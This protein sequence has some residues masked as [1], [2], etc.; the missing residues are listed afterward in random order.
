MTTQLIKYT[1]RLKHADWLIRQEATGSPKIFARHLNVSESHL[2][3]ILDELRLLGMPLA[4]NKTSQNYYYTQPV[5]L[6]IE[7]TVL[8][9]PDPQRKN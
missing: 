5:Q 8:P 9:L 1:D 7:V 6:L 3:N 2:Y 4:Y